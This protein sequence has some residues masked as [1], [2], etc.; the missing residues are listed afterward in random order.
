MLGNNKKVPARGR[1]CITPVGD[2]SS[3]ETTPAQHG[4]IEASHP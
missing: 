1:R 2:T 3:N 4:L